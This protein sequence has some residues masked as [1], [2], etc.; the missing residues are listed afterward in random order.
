M[1]HIVHEITFLKQLELDAYNALN[2]I[3]KLNHR[4]Q[5]A[6]AEITY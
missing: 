1:E 2:F 4:K 3:K 5:A 6:I